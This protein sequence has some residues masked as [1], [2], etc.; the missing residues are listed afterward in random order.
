MFIINLEI[1]QRDFSQDSG[2]VRAD[3]ASEPC[4][5]KI[6]KRTKKVT[7]SREG[8]SFIEILIF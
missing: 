1:R 6:G 3:N 5:Q 2:E 8:F 4:V 7:Y